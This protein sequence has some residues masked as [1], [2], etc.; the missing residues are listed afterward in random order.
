MEGEVRRMIQGGSETQLWSI[1]R[2]PTKP[3]MPARCCT[4]LSDSHDPGAWPATSCA[5]GPVAGHDG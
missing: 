2:M 5:S 1:W 4:G 3:Q